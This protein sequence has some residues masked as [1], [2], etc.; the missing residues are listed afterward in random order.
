MIKI[1]VITYQHSNGKEILC[2]CYVWKEGFHTYNSYVLARGSLLMLLLLIPSWELKIDLEIAL[3]NMLYWQIKS[4]ITKIV[5]A[6]SVVQEVLLS[7][8]GNNNLS[9]L[10]GHIWILWPK[11]GWHLFTQRSSQPSMYQYHWEHVPDSF[12]YFDWQ[13][14]ECG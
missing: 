3:A 1:N 14:D 7:G 10:R 9:I 6:M 11:F 4:F 2:K 8:I 5:C 13:D 12:M